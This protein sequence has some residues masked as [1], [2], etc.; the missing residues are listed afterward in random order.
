[1]T[2]EEA[3]ANLN[4]IS[5]AF[6][7]PVTKEQRKLINDTFEMAISALEKIP[8]Y[9]KKYKRWKRKALEHKPCDE[10]V[11]RKAVSQ[12]VND[13]I[14]EYI[15]LMDGAM[16]M[17]PLDVAKAI[18]RV[19]SVTVRQT[20]DDPYQTDMDDAW[21]Q[22]KRAERQTGKCKTC[23]HYLQGERDG[24]CDSYVCQHYSDWEGAE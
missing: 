5:V 7:E 20:D 1:M 15:P 12:A 3:I 10:A 8:K 22:A 4:M 16:E 21:E 9:R 24:S 6:V 23:K 17:M 13:V 2:R 14:A 19:P 11:S 18:M